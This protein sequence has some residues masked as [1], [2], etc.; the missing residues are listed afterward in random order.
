LIAIT[1][2]PRAGGRTWT[3]RAL[4]TRGASNSAPRVRVLLPPPSHPVG[5]FSF[6][7]FIRAEA[8]RMRPF[9][10]S[11]PNHGAR[12]EG[13]FGPFFVSLGRVSLTQPN[14]ARFGTDVGSAQIQ[15][16]RESPKGCGFEGRPLRRRE[17]GSKVSRPDP[18]K[19]LTVFF[20]RHS[21]ECSTTA[22]CPVSSEGTSADDRDPHARART[23]NPGSGC[24][25]RR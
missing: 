16:F 13:H 20:G 19:S 12:P 18:Q 7:A 5:T 23:L 22:S 4:S 25:R 9:L 3:R 24:R 10:A 2:V 8:R 15:W 6:T 14:H 21:L 1:L 11:C 17:P